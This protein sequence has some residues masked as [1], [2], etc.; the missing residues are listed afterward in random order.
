MSE[1]PLSDGVIHG[2]PTTP[3]VRS[4]MEE[5]TPPRWYPDGGA[6]AQAQSNRI[7]DGIRTANEHDG[8]IAMSMGNG[9][10]AQALAGT[11]MDPMPVLERAMLRLGDSPEVPVHNLRLQPGDIVDPP[12]PEDGDVLRVRRRSLQPGGVE[13]LP[14]GHQ[15]HAAPNPAPVQDASIRFG[16]GPEI[17]VRDFQLSIDR[18]V[19]AAMPPDWQAEFQSALRDVWRHPADMGLVL[20]RPAAALN[21]D[22]EAADR[23][24]NN[25]YRAPARARN[26]PYYEPRKYPFY[27]SKRNTLHILADDMSVLCNPGWVVTRTDR[28]EDGRSG[29]PTCGGCQCAQR[30]MVKELIGAYYP[31]AEPWFSTMQLVRDL[32]EHDGNVQGV[33]MLNMTIDSWDDAPF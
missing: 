33:R 27:R 17:P 14:P 30:A 22:Q 10:P 25:N 21:A 23:Y 28:I 5:I 31:D 12:D 4:W 29:V 1:R 13:F 20:S 6:P 11:S 7:A 2:E 16:D 26:L 19:V 15:Y 24:F 32:L 3:T 18:Q 8:L 9:A